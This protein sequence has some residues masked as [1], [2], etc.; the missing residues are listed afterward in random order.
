MATMS[1]G[2]STVMDEL[3]AGARSERDGAFNTLD[4]I[5]RQTRTAMRQIQQTAAQFVA[6]QRS[7]QDTPSA[8]E[9]DARFDPE[10]WELPAPDATHA[11]P[12]Q[13]SRTR[14]DQGDED[15]YPETWLR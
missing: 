7:R 4:A 14:D 2:M 11:G 3:V 1:A 12:P 8:D 13:P 5:D 6:E 15:E 9:R 10:E